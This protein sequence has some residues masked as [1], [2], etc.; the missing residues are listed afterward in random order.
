MDFI[1][2]LKRMTILIEEKVLIN[3][4][5]GKGKICAQIK[6]QIISYLNVFSDGFGSFRDSVSGEFSGEDEL[7]S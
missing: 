3:I 5:R 6:S 1:F 4:E 2:L 7:D